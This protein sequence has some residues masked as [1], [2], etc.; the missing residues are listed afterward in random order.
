MVQPDPALGFV[1]DFP[2]DLFNNAIKF[3]MQMG[4]PNEESKRVTFVFSGNGSTYWKNGTELSP[5]PAL[6][7]DGHPYDPEVEVRKTADVTLQ[8]DCAVE[9]KEVLPRPEDP[10]GTFQ[11]TELTVTLLEAEY[12]Q[13]VGCKA[14]T[15]NGDRYVYSFEPTN[16]GLFD[17]NVHQMVFTSEDDN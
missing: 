17:A 14:V 4:T 1:V 8:V 12:Q 7:L 6:D 3:A 2:T 15:Y 13:V 10:V 11:H 9:V 16:Y 5:P